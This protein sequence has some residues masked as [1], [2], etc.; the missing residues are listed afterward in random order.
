MCVDIDDEIIVV[1]LLPR[2]MG[3]NVA[4]V[5]RG[6]DLRQFAHARAGFDGF[7]LGHFGFSIAAARRRF[8][9][10]PMSVSDGFPQPNRAGQGS[11]AA[12]LGATPHDRNCTMTR[13]FA[14]AGEFLAAV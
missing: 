5:C 8:A 10:M 1:S 6:R 14:S 2:R 12:R 4:G 11:L 7:L 9:S 13:A 3:E